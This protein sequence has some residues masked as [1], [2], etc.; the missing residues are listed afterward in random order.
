MSSAFSSFF[1]LFIVFSFHYFV[2]VFFFLTL[3]LS[4]HLYFFSSSTF[5]YISVHF[6]VLF[7]QRSS[8]EKYFFRHWY[9]W[10]SSIAHWVPTTEPYSFSAESGRKSDIHFNVVSI[11]IYIYIYIYIRKLTSVFLFLSLFLMIYIPLSLS[12][13][14]YTLTLFALH[15]LIA[16][17]VTLFLLLSS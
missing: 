3:F 6:P 17:A 7:Q 12:R 9:S 15:N 2:L 8:K 5:W 11:Y 1:P 10:R 14:C 13:L 4:L 16:P